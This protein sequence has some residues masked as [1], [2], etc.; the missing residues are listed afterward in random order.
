MEA[1]KILFHV[2][3]MEVL[4]LGTNPMQCSDHKPP[5]KATGSRSR[6]LVFRFHATWRAPPAT[7]RAGHHRI[8]G[9]LVPSPAGTS[10]GKH[11]WNW[12]VDC[13]LEWLGNLWVFKDAV[14]LAFARVN[15]SWGSLC[16]GII[17]AFM[18]HVL[19]IVRHDEYFY[20][21]EEVVLLQQ[22]A[23]LQQKTC[24]AERGEFHESDSVPGIPVSL[25]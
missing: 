13:I 7:P 19:L 24:F 10:C 21:I 6:L 25:G 9:Q 11:P 16:L 14:H 22:R 8:C 15:F 12:C 18:T 5:K 4:I 17:L 23:A 1:V 20:L 2:H 3:I